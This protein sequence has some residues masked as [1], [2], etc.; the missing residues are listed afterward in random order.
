[1]PASFRWQRSRET[2]RPETG[3]R[4]RDVMLSSGSYGRVQAA[5][6]GPAYRTG[7]RFRSSAGFHAR[8]N[9]NFSCSRSRSAR[10]AQRQ[11][12]TPRNA[13]AAHLEITPRK[14]VGFPADGLAVS[15]PNHYVQFFKGEKNMKKLRAIVLM[16]V[17]ALGFAGAVQAANAACCDSADCCASCDGAC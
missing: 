16:A 6:G 12:H 3:S 1:M 8:D 7:E 10:M 4:R 14:C 2:A 5:P 13:V 15:Q 9:S 17:I 11:R